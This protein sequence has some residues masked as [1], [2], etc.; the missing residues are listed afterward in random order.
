M[1]YAYAK[2]GRAADARAMLAR[3]S[4]ASRG[5]FVD[6]YFV[7]VVYAGLGDQAAVL[8]WLDKACDARSG[9][10]VALGSEPKLDGVR[11]TPRFQALVRRVGFE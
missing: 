2:S 4:A 1:G 9:F 6:P 7:A 5:V 11:A 10:M 8:D 3:L